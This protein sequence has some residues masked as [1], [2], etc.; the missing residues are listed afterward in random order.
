MQDKGL[1]VLSFH[2]EKIAPATAKV[3]L[4]YIRNAKGPIVVPLNEKGVQEAYNA[5]REV[6]DASSQEA[7]EHLAA[8]D[9]LFL[10]AAAIEMG[11]KVLPMWNTSELEKAKRAYEN[12]LRKADEVSSISEANAI[13]KSGSGIGVAMNLV[14]AMKR[15][16][17][18]KPSVIL[19]EDYQ[20][21][22]LARYLKGKLVRVTHD[23]SNARRAVRVLGYHLRVLLE[24][25][26]YNIEAPTIIGPRK[27]RQKWRKKVTQIKRRLN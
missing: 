21:Q 1:I 26:K 9:P 22:L 4:N 7:V 20:A 10:A 6:R 5:R 16:Q 3:I 18:Q 8:L 17:E 25:R 23:S 14:H 24:S 2:G 19:A 15:I 13:R 12:V 11:K 27:M